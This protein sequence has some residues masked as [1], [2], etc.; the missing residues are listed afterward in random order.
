MGAVGCRPQYP[1]GNTAGL[2]D[3]AAGELISGDSLSDKLTLS[4][5]CTG[6]TVATAA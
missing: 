2:T 6:M 4:F 5:P 1:T 3:K